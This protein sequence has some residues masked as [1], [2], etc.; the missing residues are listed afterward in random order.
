LEELQV[1]VDEFDQTYNTERPHQ[2]LP[3]RI[4]PAEAWEATPKVE[5]PHPSAHSALLLPDGVRLTRVRD[6]GTVFARGTRFHVT[7][8]MVGAVVSLAE[9][10]TTLQVF[11]D[12]GT[13]LIEHAWPKPGTKYVGSGRPK[14][15]RQPRPPGEVSPMS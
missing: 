11:D 6:N 4:T 5:E 12:H 9:T 1:Q 10:D 3:G 2:S 13:L 7:R 15:P 8:A 14:G